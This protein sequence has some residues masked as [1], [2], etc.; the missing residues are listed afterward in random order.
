M[1]DRLA[2]AL[3]APLPGLGPALRLGPWQPAA[4]GAAR[5]CAR[6]RL[7]PPALPH[8]GGAAGHPRPG[9]A[10]RSRA[11]TTSRG[12]AWAWCWPCWRPAPAS[13]CP[14]AARGPSRERLLRRLQEAG[15]GIR[16]QAARRAHPGPRAAG[17][18]GAD[19]A[20][21][22]RSPCAG[23]CWPTSGPPALFLQAAGRGASGVGLATRMRRFRYGWGTFKMDWALSGPVPWRSAEA[24][25]VGRG[26]R[27]RQPRR[28]ERASRA[29]PR[30]RAAGQSL[31][32]HRPAVAGRS[33]PGPAGRPHAL[34]LL[35]RP[36]PA[37]E[38]G[39]ARCTRSVR[40]PH[41]A[42]ASRGWPRASAR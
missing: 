3:L 30:R 12:R 18:G 36:V 22:T 42:A 20:A 37:A 28:P 14:S 41:R 1:G 31:P 16:L 13:A 21:A 32:G 9:A 17:G 15:G 23:R 4:A 29:G 39:W 6:R 40:R 2:A 5:V 27:R 35:A 26:P 34:G 33:R 11:A 25:R 24:P 8:R 7:R 19:A 10:R 38:G